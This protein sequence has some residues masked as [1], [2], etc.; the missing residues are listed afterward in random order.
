MLNN[1]LKRLI[2]CTLISGAE[3]KSPLSVLESAMKKKLKKKKKKKAG[4]F[5]E[6]CPLTEIYHLRESSHLPV[7][8]T[9]NL[10]HLQ[11]DE[12]QTFWYILY[13]HSLNTFL[14]FANHKNSF[15]GLASGFKY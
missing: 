3:I 6:R 15:F 13:N 9:K 11:M 12:L 7:K 8:L 4:V 10:N 2:R 5:L 1:F 14:M